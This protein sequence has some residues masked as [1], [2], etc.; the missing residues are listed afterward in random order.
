[1]M[2]AGLLLALGLAACGHK[3]AHPTSVDSEGVYVDAGP[4]TYQVQI[5]RELNP[6]SQEDRQ[7]LVG[8]NIAPPK[9]D[10]FYF[11]I[12]MWARN[13]GP[14]PAATTTSFDIVDTQGTRYYPI[15][16]NPAVNPYAWTSQTLKH[17]QTE[18]APDTTASYGPTGGGLLLFKLN[19]SAFSNRPLTLEIHAPGVPAPSSVS[20]DL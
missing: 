15:A 5:S 14:H 4:L 10:E 9:P 7:Y 11:A 1:M 18:P 16:I 20:I 13:E 6:Y 17:L 8:T 19:I 3:I 12:F 2:I